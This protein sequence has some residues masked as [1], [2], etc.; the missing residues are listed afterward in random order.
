MAQGY[1]KRFGAAVKGAVHKTYQFAKKAAK[2]ASQHAKTIH[3][4]TYHTANAAHDRGH[5]TK[6]QRDKTHAT[7][8]K[9]EDFSHAVNRLLNH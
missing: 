6:E 3:A 8:H 1:I 9:V 5:I 4:V 7:A 2:F